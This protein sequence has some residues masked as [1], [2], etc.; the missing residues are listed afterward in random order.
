MGPVPLNMELWS[1]GVTAFVAEHFRLLA[2]VV[3]LT[4]VI[5]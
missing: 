4:V 3:L 1:A 2:L 5:W